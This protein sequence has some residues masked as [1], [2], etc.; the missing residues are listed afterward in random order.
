VAGLWYGDNQ[1]ARELTRAPVSTY[2]T[3]YAATAYNTSYAA[4]GQASYDLTS[5][6]SVI[7]GLRLNKEDTG[8][9]FTRYTPPPATIR[10]VTE[11]LRGDDSNTDKTGRLGL[12]HR[13]NPN[14]M[15]YATYSTGHKGVAY[16]LTSSFT[17]A[18]AKNQ[19]VPGESAHSIEAGLKLGLMNGRMS[20]DLAAFR[21]N[22][23]GF[24]QSAG[25]YDSDGVFRTTLHSIG[26][27]RTSGFEADLGWRV[28]KLLQLNGAFA[29]TRAIVTDFE[30][31]PCYS[32]LNAAGTGTTPGGNC[33]VSAKYNNTS[34]AN[35]KGATLP[36][37]PK[38]KFN[39]GGQYD[40]PTSYSYNGFRHRC[41]PLPEP[42]AVQPEPGSDDD[43][44][45]VRHLQPGPGHQGQAGQVQVH[46]P[47]QQPVRQ[48]L[49]HRPG[50][51]LGQRHLELE[52]AEP[53]GGGEHHAV[54]AGPRL[55]TLLR[56]ACGLQL[57]IV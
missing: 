48:V 8:Y 44:G 28:N 26:G 18:I 24:Q 41:V 47:D 6:T 10:T 11:Y 23:T 21:T 13:F 3:D 43:S 27:L 19:P 55:P 4:F 29:Y 25:F 39:L 9:T 40:I 52:G 7:A 12:E 33:A 35:L 15:G 46:L 17:G 2:V 20:L 38:F 31:G 50:Q 1:L 14:A 57:L 49:R 30:N 36:N 37:A 22:F 16:D 42:H 53:C 34:V 32:V 56:N 45:R 51:Q 5:T 54:D